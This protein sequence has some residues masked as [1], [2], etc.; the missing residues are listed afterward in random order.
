MGFFTDQSAEPWASWW[1][2]CYIEA[3]QGEYKVSII[4]I[5]CL[6]RK[7]HGY[8]SATPA[9]AELLYKLFHREAQ[10]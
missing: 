3:A 1:N 4:N 10:Q 9:F 2:P 7:F 8:R 5:F 6:F